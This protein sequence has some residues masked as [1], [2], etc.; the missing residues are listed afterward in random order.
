LGIHATMQMALSCY[1]AGE[2]EKAVLLVQLAHQTDAEELSR[3]DD[4]LPPNMKDMHHQLLA[5][6]GIP[7]R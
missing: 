2:L 3:F 6:A 7:V 4:R 5:K 1:R